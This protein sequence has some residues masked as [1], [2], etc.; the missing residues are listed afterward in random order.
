MVSIQVSNFNIVDKQGQ[1]AV[2]GEGHI[3]YYLDAIPPTA[4]GQPA[5][6]PSG[7]VWTT[8]ANTSFTFANVA[9]GT[10]TIWV[11]LVN[12]DHTPLVPPVL[13]KVV[14]VLSTAAGGG[15]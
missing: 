6:P 12:N 7:S 15:P 1:P 13:A 10:H 14:I 11:Q 5:T 8:T 2:A 3:H 4:S 9:A